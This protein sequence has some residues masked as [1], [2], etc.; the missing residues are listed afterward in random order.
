MIITI[1][2]IA[3]VTFI[4]S[5]ILFFI[6][7]ICYAVTKDKVA[8]FFDT[9]CNIFAVIACMGIITAPICF[10]IGSDELTKQHLEALKTGWRRQEIENKCLNDT[11]DT[12]KYKW[13]QYWADSIKTELEVKA[14]EAKEAIK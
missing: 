1:G 4:I 6:F 5:F 8:K 12:C 2:G 10:C 9:L 14:I 13:H 11:T 3:F 7:A